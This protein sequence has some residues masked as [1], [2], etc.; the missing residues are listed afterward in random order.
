MSI[1]VSVHQPKVDRARV[2]PLPSAMS[3]VNLTDLNSCNVDLYLHDGY[4]AQFV[5]DLVAAID[6]SRPGFR[7]TIIDTLTSQ[8]ALQEGTY[9]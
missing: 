9:K 2:G 6:A 1:N 5:A 3:V 8:K 7:Q 4:A